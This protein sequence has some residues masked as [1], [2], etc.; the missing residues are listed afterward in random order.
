MHKFS[1]QSYSRPM[2]DDE[3]RNFVFNRNLFG[4]FL[5]LFGQRILFGYFNL[6]RR[7]LAIEIVLARNFVNLKLY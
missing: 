3:S 7:V 5:L 6:L 4:A 1:I 2:L